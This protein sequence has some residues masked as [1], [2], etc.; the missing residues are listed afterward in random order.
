MRICRYDDSRVGIIDGDE[1]VDVTAIIDQLPSSRWP[2]PRGDIFI[3]SLDRLRPELER[4]A[5]TGARRP[6]AGA[7]LLSPIANPGKIIGAPVNYKL[8]LEESRA[9]SGI[10]FGS[11]VKT[12]EECGVF[13]KAN[14]SLVG[15]SEGVISERDDRRTDHEIELAFVIGKPGRNIPIEHALDYVAGYMI[16]LDMTIR[17]PEE[18]SL[19]KSLDTFSV[20]GPW[21]VT[22]DEFGDP[23]AVNLEL[24]IGGT[25][26]QKANTR[27]LIFD[28]RQLIAYTSK[29]YTLEPGDV[30]MTGTPEG[31]APVQPGDVMHCWIERIGEMD[32]SVRAS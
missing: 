25:S 26:R 20:L 29:I 9:D 17:G 12:I 14:S 8:H 7:R 16:G 3:A 4:L 6:I 18:R 22:A 21:L 27:D 5:K 15:P 1:I 31:V 30:I 19:R 2:Y 32:V 23:S 13:L 11:H 10:H 24:T 28:S